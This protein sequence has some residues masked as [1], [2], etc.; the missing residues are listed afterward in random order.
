MRNLQKHLKSP[1]FKERAQ[2]RRAHFLNLML[3][4]SIPVSLITTI[5]SLFVGWSE[6]VGSSLIGFFFFVLSYIFLSYKKLTLSSVLFLTTLLIVALISAYYGGN[7]FDS[8]LYMIP[9][10]II[11]SG[12][13][14][15]ERLFVIFS[16]GS[17]LLTVIVTFLSWNNITY[18]PVKNDFTGAIIITTIFFIFT[19]ITTKI[20]IQYL[21]DSINESKLNEEKFRSITEKLNLGIF[22]YTNNGII[23][24]ANDYFC[25]TIGYSREE[26][27][28]IP[29]TKI[30]HPDHKQLVMERAERRLNSEDV[31]D[32]YEIKVVYKDGSDHWIYL[33]ASKVDVQE[34]TL[35]LGGIYDITRKKEIEQQLLEERMQLEKAQKLESLGVL[36]GG[37]AHDFNN[38]L[39]GILGNISLIKLYIEEKDDIK[40]ENSLKD[41]QQVVKRASNLTNQLLTFSKGGSPILQVASLENIIRENTSFVLSGSNVDYNFQI[42]KDIW[43]VN[44]DTGQI[45]QVIQNLI[46]NAD[47]AM[48]NG[49]NI[50]IDIKNTHLEDIPNLPGKEVTPGDYV[51][52]KIK[53]NGSGIPK[54]I[55]DKIFDPYFTTKE[56]GNGLGLATVYSII[57]KHNG[58]L[59]VE[60]VQN[61][62]TVFTI[63][64]PK[65]I[66]QNLEKKLVQI[67]STPKR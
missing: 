66:E 56:E 16:A 24:Y 46:I 37:I 5:L 29:F 19:I 44:I 26:L 30:I 2:T 45:S 64:L 12:L 58:Y 42:D 60:S 34:Q 52:I 63:Y 40:I 14:L 36:A 51:Y 11:I 39:T 28:S 23:N 9:I 59:D 54:E 8:T 38:L 1:T 65:P 55:L 61:K 33:S 49:G 47:Q 4:F 13:L 27:L 62:G 67:L 48:P 41:I 35:G 50:E 25:K 17:L 7:I 43:N 22:T 53:D 15:E 31:I 3:I 57:E 21:R 10:L 20:L 32:S 18:L 6:G